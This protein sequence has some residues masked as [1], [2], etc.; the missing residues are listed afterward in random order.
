MLNGVPLVLASGSPRRKDLLTLIGY[1]PDIVFSP[2]I[3]ET[4]F[5]KELPVDLALR[6][7]ES[8]ASIAQARYPDSI[9]I[10]GDTVVALG[11]RYLDK[12]YTDDDVR[13][14]LSLLSGRRHQVLTSLCI[15]GPGGKKSLKVSKNIVKL[16]KLTN[17][18]LD[19]YV[20]AKEGIGKAGGYAIQGKASLFVEWVRGTTPSIMGLPTNVLFSILSGWGYN[21]TLD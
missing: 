3:D 1:A 8:K 17:A 12:A 16:K 15:L 11:R 19:M 6:L 10:A 2:D 9:I 13:K 21:L 20:Q 4:P 7:G 5:S 18:E 14:Y